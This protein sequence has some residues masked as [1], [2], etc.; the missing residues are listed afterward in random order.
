VGNGYEKS[1]QQTIWRGEQRKKDKKNEVKK[2]RKEGNDGE[3][4]HQKSDSTGG[5]QTVKKKVQKADN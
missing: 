1:N 5:N 2:M 3:G 4:A